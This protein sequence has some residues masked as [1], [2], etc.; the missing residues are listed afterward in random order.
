MS[1]YLAIATATAALQHLL[2]DP[3]KAAISGAS[4]GFRRPDGKD[5]D[6][7]GPIVNAYLY[8][9][10]PNAAYRNCDLPTRRGNGSLVSKPLT[11]LDL[12]YLFTFNGSDEKLEPQRLLGVVTST[13]DAQPLISSSDITGA[14]TTYTFLKDSGLE[15]QIDSVR[16][17][18]AALSLEEFTKL[19]S[20]F[21]QVEYRLSIA[22]QA[23][24]ILI[25]STD[26]P[27]EA[28]P[29]QSRN[30]YVL[31]FQE[32]VIN[33]VISQ[34]GATQPILPTSTLLIQGQNLSSDVVTVQIG[35]SVVT[36]A[37]TKV[38]NTTITLPVPG[39]ASAGVLGVQ[40]TQQLE[41]GIPSQLKP[42]PG[43]QSNIVAIV[44][45]PAITP[46]SASSTAIG[47]TIAPAVQPGQR[48]TLLLNATKIPPPPALPSAYTFALPPAPAV[49]TSLNFAITGVQAG[50]TQYFVRVLVDGAES[51]LDLDPTS[52]TFGPTVT[53]A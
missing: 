17:T 2:T 34:A 5:S 22:Y 25:E 20:A 12:H 31:P 9:V 10:T 29:V 47:L 19:W 18:P 49:T 36:P 51:L 30:I 52:L 3:V 23:S 33:Q 37:P 4:V 43:F 53:I 11:A 46:T 50:S 14:V 7:K 38:T 21:F 39:T 40:V 15:N 26:S 8:R 28:L 16:F 1:N 42:H 6:Q 32:P 41:M 45:H 35:N 48:V 44:L 27:Q 24:V 13:L